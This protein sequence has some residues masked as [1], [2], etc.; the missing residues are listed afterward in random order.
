M[1]CIR[2]AVLRDTKYTT[3]GRC[4]GQ[5]IDLYYVGGKQAKHGFR[6]NFK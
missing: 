3:E 4:F 5:I 6:F 2:I 1:H